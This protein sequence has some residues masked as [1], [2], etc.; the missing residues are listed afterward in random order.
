MQARDAIDQRIKEKLAELQDEG[1]NLA[2]LLEST[3][4]YRLKK[5]RVTLSGMEQVQTQGQAQAQALPAKKVK[6]DTS[7]DSI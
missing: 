7:S 3:Y 1:R 6:I 5:A 4:E 2:T